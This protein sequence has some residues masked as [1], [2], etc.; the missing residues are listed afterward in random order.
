M[1]KYKYSEKIADAVARLDA[2]EP[3]DPEVNH[4]KADAIIMEFVPEEVLLAYGRAEDRD[5]EWWYA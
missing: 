2:L 5:G 1:D 4:G 3:G